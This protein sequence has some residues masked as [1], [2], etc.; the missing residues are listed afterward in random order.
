MPAKKR[1]SQILTETHLQSEAMKRFYKSVS[2]DR[3]EDCFHI[4]LD[5]RSIKTPMKADFAVPSESLAFAIVD[6]WA[7][8]GEVIDPVTMPLTGLSNASIDQ[9]APNRS[10]AID[11]VVR[12]LSTDYLC[13]LG[14][15][16]LRVRQ[17]ALWGP[18][19]G[20]FEDRMGTNVAVTSGVMPIAQSRQ[21]LDR[22]ETAI[23][24]LAPFHLTGLKE[25]TSL[26]GSAI[27]GFALL[28]QVSDAKQIWQASDIDRL[29]QK[30]KWGEDAEAE[31]VAV[32]RRQDFDD[33]CV[34]LDHL[35]P[36]E[37]SIS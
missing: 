22:F 8:Q 6:E 29:V 24:D 27:L 11:D 25:A 37:A 35:R 16:D 30:E 28:E 18:Y 10:V 21:L 33:A 32:R 15:D 36:T 12:F 14:E 4:L 7:N 31:A 23:A 26:L 3:R 19:R 13:Y 1:K 5:G 2:M 9:I 17:E 34:F 20:W